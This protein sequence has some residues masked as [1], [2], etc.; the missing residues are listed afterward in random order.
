MDWIMTNRHPMTNSHPR[1]NLLVAIRGPL[2]LITLGVLFSIDYFGPWSFGRTWPVL[3]IVLGVF[4]LA[5]HLGAK[6]A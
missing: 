2:M 4:K 3:L 5:E 6:T 1:N